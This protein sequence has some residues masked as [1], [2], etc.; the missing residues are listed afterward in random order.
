MAGLAQENSTRISNTSVWARIFSKRMLICTVLGFSS[1]LP[2]YL[3]VNLV[4]AWLRDSNVDLKSFG[5]CTICV[6][7]YLVSIIRSIQYFKM[8]TKKELDDCNAGCVIVSY[9]FYRFF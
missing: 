1:G 7:I 3:L 9:S 4:S 6:E 2:L 5:F 8:G